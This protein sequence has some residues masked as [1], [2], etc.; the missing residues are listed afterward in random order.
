MT[1]EVPLS[2]NNLK[3]DSE[4]SRVIT[5]GSGSRRVALGFR[6][7][8]FDFEI[9]FLRINTTIGVYQP[10]RKILPYH[11]YFDLQTPQK[12][13][14]EGKSWMDLKYTLHKNSIN[15]L[16][17]GIASVI[18]VKHISTSDFYPLIG[19]HA[20]LIAA[21]E[22]GQNIFLE[23]E[24]K[25][26]SRLDKSMM[27]LALI[28]ETGLIYKEWIRVTRGNRRRSKEFKRLVRSVGKLN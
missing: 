23:T 27:K 9:P 26:I 16:T 13:E 17:P 7:L 22:D 28:S 1:A 5:Q 21:V 14:L 4:S 3:V 10:M 6:V 18:S 2:L 20:G 11:L 19:I 15:D 8:E 12:Y 25:T 24:G